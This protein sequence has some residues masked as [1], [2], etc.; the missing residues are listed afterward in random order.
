MSR[1]LRNILV[2]AGPT[3]EKLDPVRYL[4]NHSSGKMGYALA[5][6]AKKYGH[7]VLVSGPTALKAPQNCKFIPVVTAREME[8]EMLKQF[9]KADL[10][11]MVAAVADYRPET[12]ARQK[13]KKTADTL[14]LRLVKNPDILKK[15]GERKKNNQI[16]VGFA[17]E[18]QN[19]LA[20]GRKKLAEKNLDWIVVNNV[21]KK[22]IGFG[23]EENEAVLLSRGG[24]TIPFAKQ[25]K[26]RLAA[27]LLELIARKMDLT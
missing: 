19:A 4:S 7:V 23:A 1:K 6:A 14:I 25:D 16:L 21:A 13:I 10:T 8:K 5:Q 17:A 9:P 11:I 18:T 2:C 20:Y 22:G 26:K 24:K 12:V 3:Q 27:K 15:L